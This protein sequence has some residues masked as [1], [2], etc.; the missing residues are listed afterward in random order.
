M[1]KRISRKEDDMKPVSQT[2]FGGA[3]HEV[4]ERGN[5]WEACL[6]SILEV[7]L[8]D[9]GNFHSDDPDYDF[10]VATQEALA[11]LG[12]VCCILDIK[13]AIGSCYW[14]AT[15]PSVRLKWSWGGP[16]LH[17][18]VMKGGKVAFDPGKDGG[19][20]PIGVEQS[21]LVVVSAYVLVNND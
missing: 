10:W 13:F 14:I 11:R 12:Y 7:S 9:I 8:D 15:V 6:A 1:H 19:A 5:C 16:M 18:I 21:E 2:K 3:Q 20:Y 17:S 4:S